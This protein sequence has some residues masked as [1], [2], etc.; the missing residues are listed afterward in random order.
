MAYCRHFPVQYANDPRLR[1]VKDHIIDLVITVHEG[2][3]VSGLSAFVAEERD[4]VV[5]MGDFADGHTAF[6]VDGL[7][8]HR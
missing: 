6:D 5:E 8:L 3:A 2:G 7:R 4:H 1:L